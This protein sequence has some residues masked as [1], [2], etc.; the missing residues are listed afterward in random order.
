MPCQHFVSKCLNSVA[1]NLNVKTISFKHRI[2]KYPEPNRSWSSAYNYDEKY[3]ILNTPKLNIQDSYNSK[4]RVYRRYTFLTE[5]HVFNRWCVQLSCTCSLFV[6][7]RSSVTYSRGCKRRYP[8]AR[9]ENDR[10]SP[11]L[12]LEIIVIRWYMRRPCNDL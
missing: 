1:L 4:L 5:I 6:Q 12:S 11:S 10:K 8:W 3:I 9:P 2:L 7:S